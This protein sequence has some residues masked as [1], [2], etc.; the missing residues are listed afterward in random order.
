MT[1]PHSMLVPELQEL[2]FYS[3]WDGHDGDAVC[4][5]VVAGV[6]RALDAG[7]L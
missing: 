1:P 3:S 6:V 5:A 4:P 7:M 2:Y